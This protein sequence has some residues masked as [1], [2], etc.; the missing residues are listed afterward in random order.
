MKIS[1]YNNKGGVAKTTSVINIAY[2]MH[3]AEKKVLVVDCD[4]Q[5][6]C[7]N[8]FLSDKSQVISTDYENI[9][10]T[11]YSAYK[12]IPNEEISKYDY[13]LFDLPPVL[14][15]EVLEIIKHSDKIYVML[16]ILLEMLIKTVIPFMNHIFLCT[17]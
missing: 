8:F 7:Y 1:I 17:V 11:T 2:A 16:K 15:D 10:S 3:K 12:N 6:N 14:S 9:A 5:K 4:M 13:V